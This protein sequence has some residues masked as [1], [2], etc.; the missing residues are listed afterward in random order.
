MGVIFHKYRLFYIVMKRNKLLFIPLFFAVFY[1]A[2]QTTPQEIAETPEK[3]A[4]VHYAYPVKEIDRQTPAPK[5]FEPFYI[6]HFGRHGSR[7]LINDS[8]YKWI[9]DL[10]ADA[11]KN[12]ALTLLG[13]DVLKRLE[14]VWKIV[15]WHG[16][17]L[18]PVGSEQ[19]KGI[20]ERMYGNFPKVFEGNASLEARSTTI[21]RCVLSMDAFCERLKELNPELAIDR[22]ASI[23]YQRYLN[24][25]TQEAIAYRSAADT[26]REE[27]R[28]FEKSQIKPERLMRS[29]FSDDTYVV[30][31]IN[32]EA[33]MLGLFAVAGNMQN[34]KTEISF[35][36]L[37]EKE[38]LFDLWQIKNY[39][40]YVNDANSALN[41]GLMFE[42]AKPVL[43][44]ILDNANDAIRSGKNGATLRFAHDGNIIPLALLLYLQDTY[45]SVSEIKEVYKAWSDFKVAPMA[46]NIQMVFFRKKGSED[47]LVKFLLHE[48]EVKVPLI[49]SDILPYYKW[50]D[51][52]VF[53]RDLLK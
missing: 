6:S 33:L 4:G 49:K 42:N 46:G 22:D 17:D 48:K 32:P 9:I 24:H 23:K 3:S 15:E 21:V 47:I 2:A 16:G 35:Y 39:R 52:E 53:Y 8:E 37:F 12:D 1:V 50:K 43:R 10:L 29:I 36:D 51:V 11:Q 13:S 44:N 28:K 45:N 41:G 18:S 19:L 25:H 30:K 26:W 31:K 38:E 20:A 7:Y 27:Y 5:G 34:I 14:E 40:L